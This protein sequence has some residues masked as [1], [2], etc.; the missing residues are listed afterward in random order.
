MSRK[1]KIFVSYSHRDA[2]YLQPDSLL[3]F[4]RELEYESVA[5][6]WWDDKIATGT[7]WDEEIKARIAESDISLVLV[8]Q[9]FLNSPY[10]TK[11]EIG[12]FIANNVFIF[13][14]ILSPCNWQ[15]RKWLHTRQ[16]LPR[17]G[18]N[19]V[20]HYT[21]RGR[22][23]EL[24][25]EIL[26]ELRKRIEAISKQG[27]NIVVETPLVLKPQTPV[28]STDTVAETKP[29][30]ASL[31]AI[32]FIHGWTT[33]QVQALQ[34]QVAETL[35]RSVV[36]RDKLKDG[37]EGPEL[38]VIPG[39]EFLMGSSDADEQPVTDEK[40]QHRV[41]VSTFYMARFPVTRELYRKILD[42]Y[43][44]QWEKQGDDPLPANYVPW[45]DS[46]Q[47]CNAL[48][49]RCGLQPC[50]RITGERVEWD[51]DVDGY[52]LPTEAEWE[53]AVRA[54]T[55]TRWF[56]GDDES[57]L[58][59]YAWYDEGSSGDV[60]PVG[61]KEPNA[62]GLYDMMGN[63]WEWCWDWYG[64]Y[65]ADAVPDPVGSDRAGRRVLRGGAYGREAR[66]LRSARR[67]RD[68][69]EVRNVVIG[70]RCVRA[71]RRQHA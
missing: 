28:V 17:G 38:V 55:A 36:F 46:V 32:Q 20:R 50:Y 69:P 67:G 19:I 65:S 16:F 54:G 13:P 59:C 29:A 18:K 10:C 25:L 70:F 5:E 61:Q 14:I 40:P 30:L 42:K 68:A 7:L 63:V 3:G 64:P 45:F 62:W 53:Y 4:L 33:A 8:S 23:E 43:P 9:A 51:R 37:G 49:E 27:S 44:S 71:A 22:R 11:V 56:C 57:Q 12:E 47:F 15:A 6:F 66:D 60:H 31:S 39:G 21:E 2:R 1:I 52:R 24:F 26:Q 48:S 58:G 34:K 41:A 35:G